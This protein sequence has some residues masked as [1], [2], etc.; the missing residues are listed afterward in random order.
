MP[1]S[2]ALAAVITTTA[3]AP[4]LMP[5]ALPAVIVPSA[6]KA[7]RSAASRSAVASGR[8]CS[9]WSTVTLPLRAA[10]STGTISCWKRPASIAAAARRWLWSAKASCSARPTS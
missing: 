9:S 8:G 10:T 2:A 5:D 4:S 6:A 1:N 7:G 3:A